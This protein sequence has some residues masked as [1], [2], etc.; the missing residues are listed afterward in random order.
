MAKKSNKKGNSYMGM[1]KSTM[2]LGVGSMA[3]MGAMGAMT[4]LPGMPAAASG[5]AGTAGAGLSMLNI[6][7]MAKIGM[8]I[9]PKDKKSKNCK[10]VGRILG[11]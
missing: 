2:G 5:I 6:G 7:N 4:T 10:V 1:A 8:N 11:R 9:I 3:G